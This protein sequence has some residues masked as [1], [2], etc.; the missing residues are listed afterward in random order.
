MPNEKVYTPK[1]IDEIPLPVEGE[2]MVL[3]TTQSKSGGNFSSEKIKDNDVPQKRVAVELLSSALNT[4]S[5]R[6]LQ[7]FTLE[8]SGG[9]Q[10]GKYTPGVS[11]DLRIT[12]NGITARDESGINTF[13]LDATTGDATF[14][15]TIQ[16][17]T[18]IG[19]EVIVGDNKIKLDGEERNI[20]IAD[21]DDDRVLLGRKPS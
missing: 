1:T 2:G 19:G 18:L 17:G 9:F 6:V 13:V 3:E 10:I 8:Q 4:K 7:E 15:G 20:L 11:G 16:A 14:K 5:K 21:E 12:P